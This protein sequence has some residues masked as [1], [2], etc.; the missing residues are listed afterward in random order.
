MPHSTADIAASSMRL[1]FDEPSESSHDGLS[2][3]VMPS[4]ED[5]SRLTAVLSR[6]SWHFS[7]STTSRSA[8]IRYGIDSSF[9]TGKLSHGHM[10]LTVDVELGVGGG[11]AFR[12]ILFDICHGSSRS[13]ASC[14]SANGRRQCNASLASVGSGGG[15]S[16]VA[17]DA[18]SASSAASVG[19][20][21]GAST[22]MHALWSASRVR[23]NTR[24]TR[25]CRATSS[26]SGRRRS[27]LM[28]LAGANG[29]I[30]D[31]GA[32]AVAPSAFWASR[33]S[34]RWVGGMDDTVGIATLLWAICGMGVAGCPAAGGRG[35][36]ATRRVGDGRR[37]EVSERACVL[38]IGTRPAASRVPGS[39]AGVVR[40]SRGGGRYAGL[41]AMGMGLTAAAAPPL[42][43]RAAM[44]VGDGAA[45]GAAVAVSRLG[46]IFRMALSSVLRCAGVNEVIGW[47][48]G[49]R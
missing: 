38:G 23:A 8:S 34:G 27:G 49:N 36:I 29:R 41:C 16:G 18:A 21:T 12:H 1:F 14:Q 39:F 32:D 2:S 44:V 25:R 11:Q 6:A 33:F 37:G 5:A 45:A 30:A 31:A 43:G 3:H 22:G 4:G 9:Y 10:P 47:C 28:G 13:T 48:C 42:A 19:A 24:F 7:S 20:G 40:S 17:E 15:A 46:W 35:A 26:L